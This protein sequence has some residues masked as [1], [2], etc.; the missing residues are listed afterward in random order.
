M[1]GGHVEPVAFML[2]MFVGKGLISR[3]GY[4]GEGCVPVGPAPLAGIPALLIL[5]VPQEIAAIYYGNR[6]HRAV[7]ADA[8]VA[9]WIGGPSRSSRW[10]RIS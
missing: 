9:A 2:A 8:L 4:D 5:I 7:C 1:G 10:P 6:A 3:L